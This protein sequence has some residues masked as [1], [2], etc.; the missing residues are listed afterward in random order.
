MIVR[1]EARGLIAAGLLAIATAA[2]AA[3]VA[4]ASVEALARQADGASPQPVDYRPYYH[5]HGPKRC[6]GKGNFYKYTPS[7]SS[8][9]SGCRYGRGCGYNTGWNS[10][11]SYYDYTGP[12]LG[13]AS[14]PPPPSSQVTASRRVMRWSPITNH[15]VARSLVER[16]HEAR[17]PKH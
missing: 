2:S 5:C 9:P 7:E 10:P 16:T 8:E 12:P 17:P 6:H 4:P 15:G 13:Q 14:P 11:S 3:P 1:N